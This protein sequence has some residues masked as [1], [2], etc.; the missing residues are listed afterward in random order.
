VRTLGFPADAAK[1]SGA[2]ASGSKA[3][4]SPDCNEERLKVVQ[5]AQKRGVVIKAAVIT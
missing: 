1:A 4:I 2:K 3:L 5:F